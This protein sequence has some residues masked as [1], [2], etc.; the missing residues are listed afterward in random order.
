MKSGSFCSCLMFIPPTWGRGVGTVP[1]LRG[2]ADGTLKLADC[3]G[4]LSPDFVVGACCGF[5][6]TGAK[7]SA[8]SR[9]AEDEGP[10]AR[11]LRDAG[12]WACWP[13][14]SAFVK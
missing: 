4:G 9:G 12:R 10:G 11:Q 1:A 7:G 6:V 13:S 2:I 14:V 8:G 3:E 5:V